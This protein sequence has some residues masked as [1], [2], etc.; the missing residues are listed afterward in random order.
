MPYMLDGT[1]IVL[2][3]SSVA[4]ILLSTKATQQFLQSEPY[5][6][7]TIILD[8]ELNKGYCGLNV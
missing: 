6:D 1:H 2:L 3:R 7:V 8:Y 4:I 5:I